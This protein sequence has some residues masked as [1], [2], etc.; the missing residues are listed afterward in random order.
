VDTVEIK[1]KIVSAIEE[2]PIYSEKTRKNNCQLLCAYST[3]GIVLNHVA[4]LSLT[5]WI[6]L[7]SI[8]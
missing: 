7:H 1:G 5:R 6:L 3:A 4:V 2:F 8:L